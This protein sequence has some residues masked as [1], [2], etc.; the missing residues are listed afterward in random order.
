MYSARLRK[1]AVCGGHTSLAYRGSSALQPHGEP[2]PTLMRHPAVTEHRATCRGICASCPGHN[3]GGRAVTTTPLLPT[4]LP[5]Q[6]EPNMHPIFRDVTQYTSDSVIR[7]KNDTA[8]AYA[9]PS[10]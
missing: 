5:N 10:R 8:V 1:E 3:L 4:R 9:D 7:R 6:Q 2:S